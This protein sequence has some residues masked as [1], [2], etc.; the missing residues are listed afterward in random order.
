MIIFYRGVGLVAS[1]TVVTYLWLLLLAFNIF[2][3]VLSLAAVC[4]YLFGAEPLHNFAL[5]ILFGLICG[6]YF[7]NL[8]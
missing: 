3:G 5:A 6:T 4:V 1:F 7:I 8:H 2:H